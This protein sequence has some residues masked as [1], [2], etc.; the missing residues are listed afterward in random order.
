MLVHIDLGKI[1]DKKTPE[2]VKR[3]INFIEQL[4]IKLPEAQA[5]MHRLQDEVNRMKGRV[6]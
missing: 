3:L 5:E 4:S 1:I 2:L 6:N